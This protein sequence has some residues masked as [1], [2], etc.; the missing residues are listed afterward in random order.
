MSQDLRLKCDEAGKNEVKAP[1]V[2][3]VDGGSRYSHLRESISPQKV[4]FLVR[5]NG[6][7]PFFQESSRLV[8]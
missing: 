6:V 4:G 2:S 3:R 1:S 5:E 8:K 7:F